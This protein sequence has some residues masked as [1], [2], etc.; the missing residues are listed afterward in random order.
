MT[1]RIV[2]D[3]DPGIDDALAILLAL[4]SPEIEVEML[5]TVHGNCEVTRAT[6]NA[7]GV[8]ELA[9][10]AD[11]PVAMGAPVPLVKPL[12]TAP[13]THG[14]TGMGYAR[15]PRPSAEPIEGHAVTRLIEIVRSSPGEITVVALG[16]LT[17]LA[18]ALRLA[19][20]LVGSIPRIVV[21]GGA[22]RVG[23]NTTP[24][25]EFN[26]YCDPH[27]AQV[28]LGSGIPVTLVPLDV[29]YQVVMTPRHVDRLLEIDSPVTR[30][31]ADATRFY[32]EF[33]DEYQS[34]EGCVVNDPLAL[35][36]A[37]VPDLVVTG[38]HP[39]GVDLSAGPSLGKTF[40]DFYR[41]SSDG[42]LVDVALAVDAEAF[43]D[44]FMDRIER[45]AR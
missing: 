34:I 29:T 7:L 19:P 4:A 5:T 13:E 40:A 28:V 15:L 8:L 26:T 35:A 42:P 37:F 1:R 45:L 44:L 38:A 17:N 41:M 6:A 20:D 21:M 10:R 12:L 33:H 3:T 36:L 25:A 27:A 16:P 43:L 11:L 32:M 9:G 24:L 22:I 39:V 18:L 23:G 30:F 31:I 14:P 2:I